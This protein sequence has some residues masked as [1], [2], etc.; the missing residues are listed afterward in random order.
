MPSRHL[1]ALSKTLCRSSCVSYGP[2]VT[3]NTSCLKVLPFE[4]NR[5]KITLF[6][7]I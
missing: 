1:Q 7:K 4:P 6:V 2:R 5:R 3:D